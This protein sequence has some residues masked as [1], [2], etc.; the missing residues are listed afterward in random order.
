MTITELNFLFI[1]R[2]LGRLIEKTPELGK[3]LHMSA[4]VDWHTKVY[5]YTLDEYIVEEAFLDHG[6]CR[7][8]KQYYLVKKSTFSWNIE[9]EGNQNYLQNDIHKEKKEFTLQGS[10]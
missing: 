1:G 9:K 10:I 5:D 2:C 7:W 6:S 4:D 8:E 3:L